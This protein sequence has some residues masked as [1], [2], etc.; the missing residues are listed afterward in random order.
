MHLVTVVVGE[1]NNQNVIFNSLLSNATFVDGKTILMSSFKPDNLMH[2]IHDDLLPL[3]ATFQ[4]LGFDHGSA[5]VFNLGPKV[6]DNFLFQ[7][8]FHSI[9]PAENVVCFEQAFL[10]KFL[11]TCNPHFLF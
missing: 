10:G 6:E 1:Q 7:K 2:L 4:Y 5:Q 8:L 9:S 11:F 3:F